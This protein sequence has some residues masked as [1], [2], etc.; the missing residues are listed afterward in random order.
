MKK[1]V[2]SI[3]AATLVMCGC[4]KTNQFKV[5]LNLENANNQT[6]YLYKNT[7]IN[8]ILI[9]SA[10][11]VDK[12]AVLKADFDDPQTCYI[13]KFNRSVHENCGDNFQFFTENQ[14][15]KITGDYNDM[16][17]WTV[18]GCPTMNAL[19]AY[20]QQ[21]LMQFEDPIMALYAEM[22]IASEAGDTLKINELNEQVQPLMESY[23]NNEIEFIRSHSDSY[24]GHY[25]L[26]LGKYDFGIEVVKE[27]LEGITNESVYSK[28]VK[29]YIEKY[30]RGEVGYPSCHIITD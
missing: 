28:N 8:H 16:P 2:F 27:L 18:E 13:I 19:N 20:H 26:D 17:H 30:E 3:I 23:I 15:T 10:T 25:L 29:D 21:N 6:V 22:E 5:D 1:L 9:D 4:N 14:N 24:L 7:D 11:F 12:N